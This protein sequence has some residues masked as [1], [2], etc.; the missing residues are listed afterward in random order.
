[1]IKVAT[2]YK[3]WLLFSELEGDLNIIKHWCCRWNGDTLNVGVVG[4]M[5]IQ[6][7]KFA[8]IFNRDCNKHFVLHFKL[9]NI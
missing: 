7:L 8:F 4:G 9:A 2:S 1:M 5:E 6:Y 3:E